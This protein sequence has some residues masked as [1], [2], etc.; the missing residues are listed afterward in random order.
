MKTYSLPIASL[1]IL[2]AFLS[3]CSHYAGA[4]KSVTAVGHGVVHPP[5]PEKR[6]HKMSG[7]KGLVAPLSLISGA[8]IGVAV[9]AYLIKEADKAVTKARTGDYGATGQDISMMDFNGKGYLL[10]LHTV[11]SNPDKLSRVATVGDFIGGK[12]GTAG[13]DLRMQMQQQSVA[14]AD[15]GEAVYRLQKKNNIP[16]SDHIALLVVCPVK[17]L[18]RGELPSGAPEVYAVTLDGLYFPVVSAQRFKG[19]SRNLMQRLAKENESMTLEAYGPGGNR[20][21]TGVVDVPLA[22]FPPDQTGNAQWLSVKTVQAEMIKHH[23]KA[24]QEQL[25]KLLSDDTSA[26]LAAR[27]AVVAPTSD[28]QSLLRA[29]VHISETNQATGWIVKG[30]D[31]IGGLLTSAVKK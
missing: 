28:Q 23:N 27:R 12:F 8:D 7:Q 2:S 1:I 18:P 24:A 16:N 14:G 15:V 3:N 13:G 26:A 20:Y 21:T 9:I 22:W 30:I 11:K 17:R 31:K 6:Q 19:E 10:V 5:V 29:D 4:K 25:A